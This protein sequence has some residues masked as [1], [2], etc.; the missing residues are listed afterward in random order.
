MKNCTVTFSGCDTVL[1]GTYDDEK[2][3]LTIAGWP[4][5][6]ETN[7]PT[8]L[9]QLACALAE[10]RR[11]PRCDMVEPSSEFGNQTELTELALLKAIE[12]EAT[13]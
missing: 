6:P 11:N 2:Q 3:I 1:G 4:T 7:D 13:K 8:R 9:Q 10:V 5:L 12:K